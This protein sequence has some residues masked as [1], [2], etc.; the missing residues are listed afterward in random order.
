LRIM[1]DSTDPTKIPADAAMVAGYINGKYA[2]NSAGWARF[3]KAI[4]LRI[5]VTGI[6]PMSGDILDVEPGNLGQPEI[7]SAMSLEQVEHIWANLCAA[8]AK[9]V[10]AR[11]ANNLGSTCY[12]EASRKNQLAAAVDT[13]HCVYWMADWGISQSEAE[14]KLTGAEVSIQF[15]TGSYDTS[16]VRDDWW[17]TASSIPVIN[18]PST[19]PAAP[20]KTLKSVQ[21]IA[22]YS[23][24]TTSEKTY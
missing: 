12:I 7:T 13:A 14:Q 20:A 15:A 10:K 2:W 9:W 16:A 19:A 5:D 22:T 18:K 21:V 4:K 23:D 8:A 11:E 1:Y 3:P 6:V 17:P 24:G